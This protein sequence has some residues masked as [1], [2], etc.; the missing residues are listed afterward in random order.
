MNPTAPVAQAHADAGP[1]ELAARQRI[2]PKVGQLR[3]RVLGL[4]VACGSEGL[5]AT[6]AYALYVEAFGEPRGG[7]YSVSP[8]LSELER[9]GYVRKGAT[10]D[11]R[12][13]Y[14]A[15]AA[16][17]AWAAGEVAA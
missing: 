3:G 11:D 12:I 16:G 15:T 14:V 4:V 1:T 8:R 7:L 17:I 9:Q 13:S 5:T 10:R 2:T 6:E